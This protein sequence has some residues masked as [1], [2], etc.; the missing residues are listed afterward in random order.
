[1]PR[2]YGGRI[3]QL[4]GLGMVFATV[5]ESLAFLFSQKQTRRAGRD[6]ALVSCRKSCETKMTEK[7]DT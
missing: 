1:V 6:Y 3:Y 2:L 5:R 7:L 4:A